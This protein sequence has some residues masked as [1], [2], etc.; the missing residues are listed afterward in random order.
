MKAAPSGI[1]AHILL[2][3][4]T[5]ARLLKVTRLADGQIFGFTDHDVD[6]VFS[7]VTYLSTTS[8][9]PFNVSDKNTGEATDTELTGAFDAVITRLEVLAGLWDHA[10][11][12]QYRV[13]W[14]NL[15]AGAII[16]VTGSFGVF[17]PQEFGFRA[18]LHGLEYPLTFIAGDICGP[19]C[20]VDFGSAK[21]APGGLLADGTAINSLL[22]TDTV[23][24]TSDGVSSLVGTSIAATGKPFDGGLLTWTSGANT[25]L[26]VEVLHVDF[27]TRT[28]TLRPWTQ[29]APIAPGDGFS[30]FPACDKVFSTCSVVWLNAL[31]NQSEPHA[32]GPDNVLAYPDYVAPHG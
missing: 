6:L 13:N 28:I 25:D 24:S 21:C 11:F 3:Q 31:N 22:Q 18:T 1:A 15:S 23:A 16:D 29:I 8:F 4:T 2:G 5:T 10:Q 19:T 32:P 14:A 17:E 27:A 12:Q 9:N 7:G 20:R 30:L 26:S